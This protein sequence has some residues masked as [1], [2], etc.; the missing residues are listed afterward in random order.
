VLLDLDPAPLPATLERAAAAVAAH[1]D[2]LR[3]RFIRGAGGGEQHA[4]ED[5]RIPVSAFDLSR[6]DR[7]AQA[8]AVQREAAALQRSLDLEVGPLVRLGLFD[9]GPDAP[10]QLLVV[11]HH[12]VVD[13]ISWRILLEDLRSACEQ[14]PEGEIRLPVPTTPF[15]A[16]ARALVKH[17]ASDEARQELDFWTAQPWRE[18]VPVRIDAASGDNT[19]SSVA[20][21]AATL[22]EDETTALLTHAPERLAAQPN[23]LL[24]ASL[25]RAVGA[26]TGNG[27]VLFDVVGHGREPVTAGIDLSRTVG[28]FTTIF[29]LLLESP[30]GATVMEALDGVRRR[31]RDVPRGGLGFGLLRYLSPDAGVRQRLQ[32]LPRPEISFLYMGRTDQRGTRGDWMRPA[33]ETA[34]GNRSPRARR[35]H[36]IEVE[37]A[38]VEG[39]LQVTWI[40]SGHLHRE[41]TIE[42][43]STDCMTGLRELIASA[44]AARV[45]TTP[46]DFPA[47]RLDQRELD[48]LLSGLTSDGSGR[49]S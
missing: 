10:A 28:W 26:W 20:R 21:L 19:V 49:R 46:A 41:G 9:R 23:E 4:G 32:E 3:L 33:R 17:A 1:H 31:F 34:G 16:W 45:P 37:A 48:R 22:D 14:A 38:I 30:R 25:C 18:A 15:Q 43:L 35:R 44:S 40:Y 36:A 7:G 13:A 12:L 11:A 27:S 42:R 6:L 47:A 29:P 24:L 5:V 8:E 39:R 2:A